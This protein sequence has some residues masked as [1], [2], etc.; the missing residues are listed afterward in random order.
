MCGRGFVGR[1][2]LG[3]E[4]WITLEKPG[5]GFSVIAD[6]TSKPRAG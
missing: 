2:E 5:F 4:L 6:V 1:D 3:T